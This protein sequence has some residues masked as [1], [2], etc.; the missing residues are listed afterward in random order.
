[1]SAG[2][3][4]RARA[5]YA[6]RAWADALVAFR[7]AEAFAALASEDVERVAWSAALTGDDEAFLTGLERCYKACLGEGRTTRA[8]RAAF[9]LGFHLLSLGDQSRGTGWLTR[10]SRLVEDADEPCSE[11][12]YLLLPTVH[13]HLGAANDAAAQAAASEAARIGER[14]NDPD[15]VALAR[16][17]EGRALMRQ[18]RTEAGLALLD[19]VML[20]VTAGELS[21]IVTGIVYCNVI[22]V[23]QQMYALD[24]ARQWTL[25]LAAWCDDNA[26]LVTFTGHCL[27]H[28]TEI[29][30]L[31]GAW[32]DAI[33]EVRRV[34]ERLDACGDRDALGDACYQRA[35]LHR[36]RGELDEAENAYR[37]A[38]E[39]GR[40]PQPGLALL[41]VR[42]GQHEAAIASLRRALS[43]T[44]VEWSRA[45]LL[46]AFVE[47]ALACSA[48]EEARSASR[49]LDAIAKRF[50]TE[51]LGAIAAHARGAV[52]IADGN[53]RD[54]IEPLRHAFSVW[55]RAGAPYIA[56]R[57]RALLSRAFAGLGDDDG[58]SLE[59]DAARKLFEEL[60]AVLDARALAEN[61]A[62]SPAPSARAHG[63]SRRE[64]EVLRLV[65]S[66]K[67]NK[68]I[69]R[70]LFVSERTV[71]RHVSNI[72]TK[73]GVTSRA[74]A[75]AFAYEHRL[76]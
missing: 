65:V 69:G 43:S 41:R 33:E 73:I 42:Q 72:F 66:G 50:A 20:S 46:P 23:C 45:R 75:T 36:L 11:R 44:P 68:A 16:N 63:L 7:E 25:A 67:T 1:M 10:A 2:E 58:A 64:L 59:R 18:G 47:I 13:R 22:A 21:P 48:L 52:Y 38:S 15:L 76:V 54:A 4:E 29:L 31:G 27:V 71:D 17:L 70:E 24:R 57:I 26:Q 37:Q 62:A 60:G 5:A 40:D 49:E 53:H 19:E 56:A 32:D 34:C 28:R 61:R 8:A 14:C 74:A 30:Q 6:A 39:N 12:G 35:E 55:N 9:W 3:L 51:I